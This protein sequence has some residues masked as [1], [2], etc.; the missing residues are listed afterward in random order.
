MTVRALTPMEML[1]LDLA[2]VIRARRCDLSDEKRTQADI[3]E[4]LVAE[5]L[6]FRREA[7]LAPG[8]V[9]DF[10]VQERF[11]VEIKLRGARKKDVYRQL[12]RYAGHD[13]I[14]G[15]LLVSNLSMGLPAEIEGKPVW[16]LSL[17][18]AWL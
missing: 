13:T 9:I 1:A 12:Q 11:G 16:F 10:L 8:D 5:G 14:E 4:A 17:G 6:S 15:L 7:R 2:R 3:A 18:Q